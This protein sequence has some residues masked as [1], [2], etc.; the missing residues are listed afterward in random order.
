MANPLSRGGASATHVAKKPTVTSKT[1]GSWLQSTPS[2]I[3]SMYCLSKKKMDQ[4][5][6]SKRCQVTKNNNWNV[7]SSGYEEEG[8]WT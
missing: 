6:G 3:S 2:Q 8:M 4:G 5:Y 1:H 7:D